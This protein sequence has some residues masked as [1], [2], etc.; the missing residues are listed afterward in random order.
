MSR[1][2][3][4]GEVFDA[5]AESVPDRIMT[6]CGERR[7]SFGETLDQT[8]RLAGFLA[9]H[10]LGA[11]RDRAE[12][13]DW[14]CGQDRVAL[15]MHNDRYTDV[16]IGCLKARTV[17][18]NVNYNYTRREIADLL[19]Y[20]QPSAAIYHRC[21]GARFLDV[22]A[23]LQIPVLVSIDD[24]SG[25][26]QLPGAVDFE[27]AVASSDVDR[28][29]AA[30]PDD[31]VML[32]TG[33]TTGRPKG[34]LWRQCDMY[35]SS[36]SGAD[37]DSLDEVRS[38]VAGVATPWFALSPLMHAAG[39]WTAFN[40]ILVGLPVVLYDNSMK[41]DA[42]AALQIAEREKVS[43]MTMVGDAYA[44]P[45]VD[46]LN[47]RSY[48]LAGLGGIGIGGAPTNVRCQEALLEHLPHVM[49]A[50][51]YGSSETGNV[52]FGVS[53][54]GA[55]KNRFDL[56]PGVTVLSPDCS[57][58]LI[59][60]DVEV[61]WVARSGRIPLGYFADPVAT[62][63]TFRTVDG[64]RM[65][66]AGDRARIESDGTLTLFGRDSQVVNTGGE[67]VFVEE[68]E[69]VLR[70]HPDVTDALVVGRPSE[71]WGQEIVAVLSL[72]EPQDP[73]TA[74][75]FRAHCA[76]HLAGFKLPKQFIVVDE[77]HRLGNG[78]ADYRWAKAVANQQ[79]SEPE[80]TSRGR[81]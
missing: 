34:V 11:H 21:L 37:H 29:T 45:L 8:R 26:A 58:I 65:V 68:V 54:A 5:V 1:Q 47:R 63:S 22:F 48:D 64:V 77:V 25:A 33:G 72:R 36:M 42:R 62:R 52:G 38:R 39:M 41:F 61:G 43:M 16:V 19:R 3:T 20:V 71:R 23:D 44:A 57:R 17:P 46:E 35:V 30:S 9:A 49:L 59:P 56:R 4:I 74:P 55:L 79:E 80:S 31:L 75:D 78:K 14:E 32:C 73:K 51:G 7:R 66:L 70:A 81:R 76:D 60:G 12:L 18:V 6:I 10:G 28:I 53:Q 40:A 50:N 67:K 69:E 15:I 27:Q 2:W 13:E 24:G